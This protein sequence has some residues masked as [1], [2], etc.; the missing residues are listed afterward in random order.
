MSFIFRDSSIA[1]G[2][3][4]RYWRRFEGAYTVAARNG[5]SYNPSTMRQDIRVSLEGE[6]D[7]QTIGEAIRAVEAMAEQARAAA[8]Q[9]P[10]AAPAREKIRIAIGPGVYREKLKIALPGLELV[11]SGREKTRIVWDDSARTPLPNGE[12]MGTFNSYTLYVGAP[13]TRLRGLTVENSAGDGRIVGQAVALY[14]DADDFAAEDCRLSARQDTLC[15]G[16][17]PKNP[18]PKGINLI[19]PVAGLGDRQPALPFHQLYRR[20]LIEGDVDFIFGSALAV[21]QDCEIHSLARLPLAN[22]GGEA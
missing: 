5:P 21:F 1:P 13:G 6:A 14:A 16:P 9:A 18:P 7:F 8:A 12:P 10:G 2:F 17:L 19:H 15:T 22:E 11:G 4:Q 20:C 3:R